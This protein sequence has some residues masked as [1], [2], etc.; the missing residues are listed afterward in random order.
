MAVEEQRKKLYRLNHKK[1]IKNSPVSDERLSK[2]CLAIQGGQTKLSFMGNSVTIKDIENWLFLEMY[3]MW[4]KYSKLFI[5]MH[6][7]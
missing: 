6:F 4:V 1:Q 5:Y 3:N 2:P 7:L